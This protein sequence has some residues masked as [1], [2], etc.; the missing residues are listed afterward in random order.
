MIEKKSKNS[1][2]WLGAGPGCNTR[3]ITDKLLALK[4]ELIEL[5][6]KE[7]ELDQHFSWA[8]QSIFNIIDDSDNKSVS[9]LKSADLCDAFPSDT[10]LLIQGPIGTQLEVHFPD[11]SD[12]LT[13]PFRSTGE[14]KS[15]K[16]KYSIHLKSRNGPIEVSLVNKFANEVGPTVVPVPAD[17]MATILQS[18]ISL[19]N[20]QTSSNQTTTAT[21]STSQPND[22]S[23]SSS[24]STDNINK[25]ISQIDSSE[26]PKSKLSTGKFQPLRQ[27]SPRKAAQQHLFV[28]SKRAT[29][30]QGMSKSAKTTYLKS[31]N[32]KED[33][34]DIPQ[35]IENHPHNNS[36][37]LNKAKSGGDEILADVLQPL[38]KLSPP[39]NGRDYCF[40]LDQNEGVTDL[41]GNS[42]TN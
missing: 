26:D 22:S 14:P 19:D 5:E 31:K 25:L 15:K 20:D 8:K 30:S 34:E 33:R 28:Q 11:Q 23:S 18:T 39:P 27:L 12:P 41:F 16:G 29:S 21:C 24:Q 40:N 37:L 1:I 3:E 6:N 7:M 2:Q 17:E 42:N 35:D 4:E 10:L 32:G 38:V 13:P 9:W 36:Q